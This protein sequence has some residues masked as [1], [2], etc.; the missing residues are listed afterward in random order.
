MTFSRILHPVE[1]SDE[2]RHAAGQALALAGSYRAELDVL[3]VR[4][5]RESDE[6]ESAEQSRLREFVSSINANQVAFESVVRYGDPVS[7]VVEYA[8]STATDLVLVG[9][10]GRRASRLWRAGVFANELATTIGCPTLVVPAEQNRTSGVTQLLFRN[11]LCAIDSSPAAIEALKQAV[12]LAKPGGRLTAIHVLERSPHGATNPA[13]GVV[14]LP[15]EH[16]GALD[17]CEVQA[18]I[19]SGV[20][21]EAV[22][23]TALEVKPDLIVI[24]FPNRGRFDA[25]LMRSTAVSVVRRA[26]CAVLMVPD[27]ADAIKPAPPTLAFE[28]SEA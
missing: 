4:S 18:R 7:A 6:R 17:S 9:R 20:L 11:S 14:G 13:P 27:P 3:R 24:G 2:G 22:L 19:V 28:C 15:D 26:N 21:H 5:R 10:T 8:R 12:N 1:Y 25:V 16:H 23:S